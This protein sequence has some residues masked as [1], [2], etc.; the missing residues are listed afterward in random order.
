M[1]SFQENKLLI[2]FQEDRQN[3]QMAELIDRGRKRGFIT[4][5]DI[6]AFIPVVEGD[7]DWLERIFAAL[8]S[9][10]ISYIDDDGDQ[11][12][13]DDD[14]DDEAHLRDLAD[15]A[16]EDTNSQA[17]EENDHLYNL[18]PDDLIGLYFSEAA[19]R[20]LLT[21]D[22][23][24]EL[25]QRIESGYAARDELSRSWKISDQRRSELK[26]KIDDGWAAVEQL[27]TANSRLVISI[28]RKYLGRGVPLLDL[29]QEGNIG[30]MRAAKKFD[31][32]RGFKFSTYATWWI[33]QAV[34]R[35]IAD[36]GRTIRMPVHKVDQ[37]SK[38][39]RI[40]YQ[41]KQ[42]LGRDPEIEDIAEALGVPPAKVEN[43]LLI[44]RH[45]LSLE[46]PAMFEDDS[47]LGDFIEDVE[48][49]SLSQTA[50]ANLLRQDLVAV[51][52]ELPAREVRILQ[53]RYGLSGGKRHTLQE[54]GDKMG[55]S[56]ER[57]RQIESQALNRLRHPGVCHRLRDYLGSS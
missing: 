54:V 19:R 3:V 56:R 43:M 32:Q 2:E 30:L 25:A 5:A 37:V 48:S 35:A 1:K 52:G 21:A 40:Q 50:E 15:V 14:L 44:A 22:Q 24:V 9:A 18:D 31:Y 27:I 51:L 12:K 7:L 8:L 38:M 41:L 17:R 13:Q 42:S 11:V 45:P 46:M 28:A 4:S 47:V 39:F 16:S 53:L 36:Q 20:P 34:T 10:G 33:R 49:P 55:V 23:E 57:V 29:I 26:K 6:F